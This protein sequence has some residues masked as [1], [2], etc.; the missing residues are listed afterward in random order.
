M[1]FHPPGSAVIFV[2]TA[3]L[4][5]FLSILDLEQNRTNFFCQSPDS[6]YIMLHEPDGL[7]HS[8]SAL[9]L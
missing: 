1:L 2:T 7:C 6:K 9:V 4:D 5:F 3:F 8:Y